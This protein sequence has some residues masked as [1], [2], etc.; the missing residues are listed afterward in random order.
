LCENMVLNHI[1]VLGTTCAKQVWH[2]S[3]SLLAQFLIDA[4]MVTTVH[5]LLHC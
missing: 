3:D 4:A 1:L 5:R 2:D